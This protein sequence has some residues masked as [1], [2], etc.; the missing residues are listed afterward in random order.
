MTI[1]FILLAHG[2]VT[3]RPDQFPKKQF[4]IWQILFT[5]K[6]WLGFANLFLCVCPSQ[7]RPMSFSRKIKAGYLRPK[8][9][10]HF[11]KRR[12]LSNIGYYF[13]FYSAK[14]RIKTTNPGKISQTRLVLVTKISRLRQLDYFL[15][16]T[17]YR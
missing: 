3:R 12:I 9:Q 11:P 7:Q 6:S 14:K 5:L 10:T 13:V 17:A 4:V 15:E 16:V 2:I 1:K 8:S